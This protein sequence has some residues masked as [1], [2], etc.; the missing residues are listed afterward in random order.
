M[1]HEAPS[2]SHPEFIE[3]RDSPPG[4]LSEGAGSVQAFERGSKGESHAGL[5][6][7]LETGPPSV[8]AGQKKAPAGED[9]RAL[10][11]GEGA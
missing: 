2:P 6:A 4:F 8:N 10:L 1:V 9:Q 7:K 5:G 11:T 3:G